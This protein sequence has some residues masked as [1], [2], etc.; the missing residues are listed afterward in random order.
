M[1]FALDNRLIRNSIDLDAWIDPAPLDAALKELGLE[2]FWTP[3]TA[4][5]K[6]RA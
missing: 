3:R 4:D 6:P 1:R 5:G 2:S